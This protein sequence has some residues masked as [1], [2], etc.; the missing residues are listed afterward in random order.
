LNILSRLVDEAK[1]KKQ[2]FEQA[3]L[4]THQVNPT[5][6][7]V[8]QNIQNAKYGVLANNPQAQQSLIRSIQ[9]TNFNPVRATGQ[10]FNDAR[11]SITQPIAN[12]FQAPYSAARVA[13]AAVTQNR[14]ALQNAQHAFNSDVSNNLFW[15]PTMQHA[16]DVAAGALYAPVATRRFQAANT[17]FG[18]T[19]A[20]AYGNTPQARNAADV[21]AGRYMQEDL[22]QYLH[23]Y[24]IDQN[25]SNA[26]VAMRTGGPIVSAGIQTALNATGVGQGARAVAAPASRQATKNLLKTANNFGLAT[27]TTGVADTAATG[28]TNAADYLKAAGVGYAGGAAMPLA[29]AVAQKGIVPTAQLAGDALRS[30][31]QREALDSAVSGRLKQINTERQALTERMKG[32]Q[33][34]GSPAGQQQIGQIQ[35][36]LA[37]L[38]Q[39]EM[40]AM[41]QRP[42]RTPGQQVLDKLL[43]MQP[44][45]S[46]KAVPKNKSLSPQEIIDQAA[47]HPPERVPK[48]AKIADFQKQM[49]DDVKRY[50]ELLTKGNKAVAEFD[51]RNGYDA[52]FNVELKRNHISYNA[53]MI[54]ALGG[55]PKVAGTA[56]TVPKP[57][58]AAAPTYPKRTGD[59]T[60]KAYLKRVGG[61]LKAPKDLPEDHAKYFNMENATVVPRDKLISSKTAAENKKGGNNSPKFMRA[62]YDGK[63]AKRD[64][65]KVTPNKNG[66]YQI[67]DGNGTYTGVGK[68]GWKNLPVTV[69]D[70]KHVDAARKIVKSAEKINPKFQASMK[71]ISK[72]LGLTY[73]EGPVKG[74][75]R[76]LEKGTLEYDGDFSKI[77]DS[78]R[79]T[80]HVDNPRNV[81]GIISKIGERHEI[82]RVKDGYANKMPGYKD[83]K[84]NVREPD[85]TIA[86]ILLAT[87]E[88]LKAKYELGGHKLYEQ[89][90]TT[91]DAKELAQLETQMNKLYGEADAAAERRLASSAVISEPSTKALAGGNGLPEGTV[92]P[93]TSLPSLTRRTITSS[94]SKNRSNGAK[95]EVINDVPFTSN[96][97]QNEPTVKVPGELPTRGVRQVSNLDKAFRSTRSIIERQG[98]HGRQLGGMLQKA[99]DT[100]EL[101]LAELEKQLPTLRK[102]KGK[103]FQSFVYATQ[104]KGLPRN[105]EVAQAV[106]EWQAVHPTIRDRA[107]AAG[108]DVGDLGPNYY[109]HFVDYDKLFKNR[110]DYNKAVNH[111]V[112]SGQAAD[113]AAAIKLLGYAR[114]VS[115]NRAFGNLEASRLADLPLYDRTPNSLVSYLS[116]SAKRIAQ[117]ET[118][119]AKDQK[120]LK[121]IAKAGEDGYD[122][123]AMKNA[124]DVAVGAKQYNPTT[125]KASS[126]IRG[127][128]TTT[129]LG[130]S[131]LTN[132]TQPVNTGIV[133]G[134][135]RTMRAMLKQFDPKAREFAADAGVISDAV[136]HDLRSQRGD[137]F[138]TKVL[139]PVI[140][141][142][143]APGFATVEKFNRRVSA[144]AGRDYALRLAQTG[145]EDALRALG[146]TGPIEN[147]TLTEAQQIQAARRV[148]EKTQF[149]VDPQDLPGW[150]DTPGGKLVA[151]FRTFSYNQSKFFSNEILKPAKRGNFVP[152]ARL[153]AALPLG[154]A[155][156]ETKRVINRRSEDENVK[157]RAQ[158]AFQNVGGA[159]LVFDIY[160]SLN[161]VGSKYIPPDRRATMATG[162]AFGPAVGAVSQGVAAVSELI[163]RKNTPSNPDRLGGKLA[164]ANTGKSYTDATPAARFALSQIPVI[165]GPIKNQ[166]LP[167]KKESQADSGIAKAGAAPNLPLTDKE[168]QDI[169]RSAFNSSEG[170]KFMG[171]KNDEQRKAQYPEL[172]KQLESMRKGF[173]NPGQHDN[174]V[175]TQAANALDRYNRLDAVGRDR[176][177]ETNKGMEYQ[178]KLAEYQQDKADGKLTAVEEVRR[179]GELQKQKVGADFTKSTRD[180]YGLSK[181]QLYNYLSNE[182]NGQQIANDV[183]QYGDALEQVGLGDNKFRDARGRA[184]FKPQARGGR[185]RSIKPSDFKTPYDSSIQIRTKGAQLAR[186]AKLIRKR[187]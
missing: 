111:L 35:K 97:A 137:N 37:Q 8:A 50:N 182:P 156:Y 151:Q 42:N 164:V 48:G 26:Q 59:E 162:V 11:N 54:K 169:Y 31:A 86:E 121:L 6:A 2:E 4:G 145:K 103:D 83:I 71:D 25:S 155:M 131:A 63:V 5:P 163:Q 158:A 118:F 1:K 119:G 113:Q 134:H 69:V 52:K 180:F 117:T 132:A 173:T 66:T 115:R 138:S 77:Q 166:L 70:R 183:L 141:K 76:L 91:V 149:K 185:G 49:D 144:V 136:L 68:Y 174:A 51:L 80:I 109:P 98:K 143:T 23:P 123:E 10:A 176:A 90:R 110:N 99:R 175:D 46:M 124:Y 40:D 85:G 39:A 160:N 122:T 165:G 168:K 147:K 24:G 78:V 179:L 20:N 133:T 92:K 21:V 172:Y 127:Y 171:L 178:V 18:D 65:I 34:T 57:K 82:T 112:E 94:T 146:V 60:D 44:G 28:S 170:K 43:T 47:P 81:Q 126:K 15:N 129:R 19:L 45:N 36:R 22:N 61:K 3:V 41:S 87:P 7:P 13:A 186:N 95:D 187:A 139:G 101:Y 181:D 104:D 150:T 152:F 56:K 120:A 167:Y 84:V 177:L 53:A 62:A 27:A 9:P 157:K 107:V 93:D 108:L 32:Y 30:A 74:F 105:P 100:Q 154:Y 67:L 106:K 88:M 116:G 29:G 159:G 130:L 58:K 153:M 14:P 96:I 16:S 64:P 79:G 12:T 75:D 148:V 89:A 17:Q 38:D 114:S 33:A 140:Q 73:Q 135:M 125:S 128:M 72:E 102:L 55:E 184:S 142:I 161:P